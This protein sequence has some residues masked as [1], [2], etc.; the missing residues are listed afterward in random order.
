M[1]GSNQVNFMGRYIYV[2]EGDDGLSATEVAELTEPQAVLGGH[3]HQIAY[4]DWYARHQS[5]GG[6]LRDSYAH[7]SADVTQ[8]QMYGEFLLA[9]AGDDGF[10]VYDIAN[11][12]DKDFSQRIVDSPFSKVGQK[13][14]V[15]TKDATGVAVGSS[16]PLDPRRNPG[17]TADQRRWLELNEEQPLA[18][19]FGYAFI[20]D[21]QEG[22]VTV[23]ITTLTD[24][25]NTN[26]HLKRGATFNPEGRLTNA[27]S[28]WIVGNYAYLLTDRALQVV[29]ISD[30]LKPR[31]VSEVTTPLRDPRSLAVQF[32][33]CFVTDAEG[34][35]VFDVTDLERPRAVAGATVPLRDAHGLYLSREY[36]YI[37]AGA[38]GLAI[39]DIQKSEQPKLDQLFNDGG[40]LSDTRD[41]KVGMT[42]ASL[43][44]YVADGRNGLKV[45]ELTNPNSVP[46]NMGYSPRPA[47]RVVA[48]YPTKG[49]AL[50][51]SEGYRRDRGVDESGN[52]I[53]VFGRRGAR[54]FNLEEQR[55][56]YLRDGK[57]YTVTDEPGQPTTG[58]AAQ[59]SWLQSLSKLFGFGWLGFALIIPAA[60]VWQRKRRAQQ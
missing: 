17:Q 54:P 1:Q 51:V 27:R 6:K 24:G 20:S 56:M 38:D 34:L 19:L 12:A 8:V 10:V 37:G 23:D 50:Q 39:V 43:F 48:Y 29:N 7:R 55:R 31:W 5:R 21:R 58:K 59:T 45:V 40:K 35:K 52:Q 26:N 3:L 16:A 47:P 30:P 53:A 2:A 14:Y 60:F 9:A 33:Y 32:R 57:L 42:Y 11:V 4:P 15:R 25:V 22:L 18:P 41:V 36:A 49:A 44:A 13:L 46:G 28:V